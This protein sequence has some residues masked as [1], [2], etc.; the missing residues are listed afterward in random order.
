MTTTQP[1]VFYWRPGCGFCTRL[2]RALSEAG[3][4]LDERNIW[5]D[6]AAAAAVR[7]VAGGNETVPTVVVEGRSLVNPAPSEVLALL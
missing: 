1:V 3:V 5:D 7:A 2:H 6:D 4:D